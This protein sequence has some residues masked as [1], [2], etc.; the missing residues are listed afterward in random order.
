[1]ALTRVF[2][3]SILVGCGLAETGPKKMRGMVTDF[4][5]VS[6]TKLQHFD[7]RTTDGQVVR[8]RVEG[9]VGITPGHAREHMLRGEPI[10]VTFRDSGEGPLALLVED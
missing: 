1:M 5:A 4:E 7:V 10:T 2:V 8:F 9:E 6:I 3:A